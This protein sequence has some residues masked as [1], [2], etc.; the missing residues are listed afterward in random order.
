MTFWQAFLDLFTRRSW[1]R[2]LLILALVGGS[3]AAVVIGD[4]YGT[5]AGGAVGIVILPIV[6]ARLPR[7]R[8]RHSGRSR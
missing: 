5:W 2:I 3:A 8:G 1:D 4:R 6:I 7:T